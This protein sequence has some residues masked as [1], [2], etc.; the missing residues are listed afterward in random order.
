M[1]GDLSSAPTV[2]LLHPRGPEG[3]P[4]LG[5]GPGRQRPGVSFGTRASALEMRSPGPSHGEKTLPQPEI[6]VAGLRSVGSS[7][8]P[9]LKSECQSVPPLSWLEQRAPHTCKRGLSCFYA[10]SASSSV[11]SVVSSG[12]QNGTA[13]RTPNLYFLVTYQVL[14]YVYLQGCRE[15]QL[16]IFLLLSLPE[17]YSLNLKQ[18]CV[19]LRK[20]RYRLL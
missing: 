5:Q 11:R 2:S 17:F 10:S 6:S 14:T 13:A 8:P 7:R 16:S 3:P 20:G 15:E 19:T 4:M 1:D 9:F 12:G 18:Y